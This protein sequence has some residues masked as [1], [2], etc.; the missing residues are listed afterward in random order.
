MASK[1]YLVTGTAGFIGFHLAQKLLDQGHRVVGFDNLNDYY[2]V[3][4]K[5]ARNA[6]LEKREGYTFIKSNL[7]DKADV[8]RVFKEHDFATVFHLAA[9]AGVRYSLEHPEAYIT[10]NIDGTLN[11]LEAARF[12]KNKPHLLMASSSSVYGLSEKYPLREDDHADRPVAL[13]GATKRANELMGHSYAHLF[14]LRVTMLRFFTVYGPWGRPDMALFMFV[15]AI[16]EDKEIEVFNGG[17][18]IRDFTYVADIVEGML[19][20]DRSRVDAKQPLYDCFNIGCAN[21]R[22]LMEFIQA[23]EKAVEKKA[24]MKMMPFQPGDIYKTFADV[25]KLKNVCG[26]APQTNIEDG[27][28]AFVKWYREFYA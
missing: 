24:K 18:M 2:S 22:T 5:E 4:L 21:P 14:G 23:I 10:S 27:I 28:K 9:Q 17:D 15:K 3:A 6:L 7:E 25:S 1:T 12:S 26:Y 20:L 11:I 19:G 13:Y 8:V 16:L